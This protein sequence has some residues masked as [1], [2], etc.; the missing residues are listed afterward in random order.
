M[1][2]I[3]FSK[4]LIEIQLTL[5]ISNSMGP[6]KKFES[7][8]VRLKR[9]YENTGSVVC[10]TMKGR[11]LERNFEELKPASHVPILGTILNIFN[12]FVAVFFSLLNSLNLAER[13]IRYL[14][15]CVSICL[16]VLFMVFQ[17]LHCH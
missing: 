11:Q 7:T 9:S 12:V 15:L 17:L 6:W 2:L 16:S 3:V 14:F 8:I 5:V 4:L 10:L 1:L 13:L